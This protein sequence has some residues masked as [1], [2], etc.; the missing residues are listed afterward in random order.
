MADHASHDPAHDAHPGHDHGAHGGGEHTHH[1]NYV[2]I[3]A[4][5]L[6]LLVISVA[7]PFLE[8]QVITLITAFGIALVKAYLVVKHFMHIDLAAKLVTYLVVTMLL[9]MLLFF[10][11]T[12]PDVMESHGSNW[13]KPDWIAGTAH[14]A[15]PATSHEEGH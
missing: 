9:F 6:V 14:P 7:G 2:K 10:A 3:W 5:L 15:S 8:I 12:A 4:V 1:P 13:E 11:G